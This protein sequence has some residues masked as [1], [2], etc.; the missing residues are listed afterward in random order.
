[1]DGDM[2]AWQRDVHMRPDVMRSRSVDGILI[3]VERNSRLVRLNPRTGDLLWQA[4]ISDVWGDL[5]LGTDVCVYLSGR[6]T[7][8]AVEVGSGRV[9]WA[10]PGRIFQRQL[11]VV[12][13]VVISGA[14]RGYRPMQAYDLDSGARLWSDSEPLGTGTHRPVSFRDGVL[15]SH[16][17]THELLLLDPS[18]GQVWERW[19]LPAPVRSGIDEGAFRVTA[20]GGV[21][22][23]CE[24]TA[25]AVLDPS[26]GVSI[27]WDG[28]QAL[29]AAP[30][31]L[32]EGRLWVTG[33]HHLSLIDVASGTCSTLPTGEGPAR[34]AVL[35]VG[36]GAAVVDTG[37]WLRTYDQTGQLLNRCRPTARAYGGQSAAPGLV[38]LRAKGSI[39]AVRLDERGSGRSLADRG[40]LIFG[41]SSERHQ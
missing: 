31:L 36:S 29:G 10:E 1:M 40:P 5:A 9:L 12:G 39:I 27:L 2:I 38:H 30:P 13:R 3:T 34:G 17:D 16:R 7:M 33:R 26:S 15:V 14:W 35:P 24:P 28:P 41:D 21:V 6:G 8:Y 32:H 20:G 23:G 19:D 18:S 37:G 22:F 25:I 4:A 11:C